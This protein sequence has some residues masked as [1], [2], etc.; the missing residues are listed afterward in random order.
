ML[1]RPERAALTLRFTAV[2][3]ATPRRVAVLADG[4]PVGAVTVGTGPTEVTVALPAGAGATRLTLHS[5]DGADTPSALGLPDDRRRLSVALA[6]VE[7]LS[8]PDP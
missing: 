8:R 6:Q 1:E 4:A 7:L 3:L 5:L 2:S